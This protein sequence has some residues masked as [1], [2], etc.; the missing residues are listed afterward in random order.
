MLQ[1]TLH[2]ICDSVESPAD[3]QL[4]G[5]EVLQVRLQKKATSTVSTEYCLKI[6][7][8]LLVTNSNMAK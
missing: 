8:F 1:M 7:T 5:F 4:L 6:N 3:F 2:V